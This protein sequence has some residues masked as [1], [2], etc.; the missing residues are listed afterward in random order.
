MVK[1]SASTLK[2][3]R[4]Q[5]RSSWPG[6]SWRGQMS[7]VAAEVALSVLLLAYW[8]TV[9][10]GPAPWMVM[11]FLPVGDPVE[12]GVGAG[13]DVDGHR[14]GVVKGDC[15]DGALHGAEVAVP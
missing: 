12:L 6:M 9:R 10:S 2:L 8:M 7:L 13:R 3:A 1:S 14:V 5:L 4:Q 11:W 15:V